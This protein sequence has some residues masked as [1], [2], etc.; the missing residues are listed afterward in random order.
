MKI[1][2]EKILDDFVSFKEHL[3][4]P[5]KHHLISFAFSIGSH[6]LEFPINS[7]TNYYENLFLF[8]TPDSKL[9]SIGIN[10][11]IKFQSTKTSKFVEVGKEFNYWRNNFI[12]NWDE[13]GISD[14]SIIFCSAK[15][16]TINSSKLWDDFDP[17][18]F[19]VPQFIIINRNN[20][21]VGLYNFILN[22]KDELNS[23]SEILKSFLNQINILSIENPEIKNAHSISSSTSNEDTLLHWE[24]TS[25]EA[26]KLLGNGELEK[27]VLSRCYKFDIQYPINWDLILNMLSNRFPDCYLFFI[28]KNES[29]FFGSSPEMFL[30][31]SN[32]IA[33]V[34]SVAGSAA[35]GEKSDSD[36]E[37]EK[38]LRT[39]EKNHREHLIVSEFIT[40]MLIKYSDNVRV[41]E[42]KQIR[43]LDNIQHLITK[44]SAVLNSEENI[45]ELIDSLFPT[46]A[47]CGVPKE[48]AFNAIRKLEDHDRG[49]YSG[50]TGVFD[51][52]GNCELAVS[53]R[54][55]LVKNR[56]VTAFAGAGFVI[57]S[58]PE[59]EFRETKLKL[60]TILYLFADESKSKQK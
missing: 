17:I 9:K 34:E 32:R 57:N 24:A 14:C 2:M 26:I 12:N 60:N 51:F 16:D 38:F 28:H 36:H 23:N 39:S 22:S 49:L 3:S 53:I 59:E 54:S 5:E 13:V 33:E 52:N 31:I 35:R 48:K 25:R 42:E 41:I 8:Q 18:D 40:D 56:E 30:K 43:K 10:S 46:P 45:F 4:V 1:N 7:L 20:S 47:V 6:E 50:L 15:F 58:E 29:V 55:A 21:S 44:F 27:L 19:Y 37:F 11:V